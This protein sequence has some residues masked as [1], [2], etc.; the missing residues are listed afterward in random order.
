MSAG[1]SARMLRSAVVAV[2]A[3]GD[4]VDALAVVVCRTPTC[5]VKC[6]LIV[7]HF[8]LMT[9]TQ[10]RQVDQVSDITQTAGL[11]LGDEAEADW[12]SP[13]A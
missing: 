10:T 9:R 12:C 8:V 2:G 3:A 11:S 4:D 13:L 7:G 5:F 6:R 1:H